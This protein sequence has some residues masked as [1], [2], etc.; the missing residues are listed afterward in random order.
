[1]FPKL[2]AGK[3]RFAFVASEFE[4][5]HDRT[6]D[7]FCFFLQMLAEIGLHFDSA[8]VVDGRMCAAQ[9]QAAVALA[10]VVRLS[11]GDTPAQFGYLE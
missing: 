1:M 11:G 4:A 5:L 7:Y 9:A 3:K 10:D 8:C 2:L 6:D